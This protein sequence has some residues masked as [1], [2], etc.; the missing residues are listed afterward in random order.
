MSAWIKSCTTTGCIQVHLFFNNR[1]NGEADFMFENHDLAER[2]LKNRDINTQAK[3]I[4]FDLHSQITMVVSIA[5]ALLVSS[6][7][8]A[9][10]SNYNGGSIEN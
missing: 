8:S 7:N 3:Q 5:N 1:D 9:N 6:E 10:S 2:Y 4:F